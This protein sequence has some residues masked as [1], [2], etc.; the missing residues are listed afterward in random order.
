MSGFKKLPLDHSLAA[1]AVAVVRERSVLGK[2]RPRS[3]SPRAR[4]K[5]EE[6]DRRVSQRNS[7]KSVF[8]VLEA[9]ILACKVSVRFV[10]RPRYGPPLS[11]IIS[12]CPI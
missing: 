9:N 5:R 7:A 10:V 8:V 12:L 3:A 4:K 2:K 6:R 1:N 11:P